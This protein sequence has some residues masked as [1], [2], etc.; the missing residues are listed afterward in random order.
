LWEEELGRRRREE[1][2][3]GSKLAL[4]GM[5]KCTY[6]LVGAIAPTRKILYFNIFNKF[7]FYLIKKLILLP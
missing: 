3:R 4:Q 6:K 5:D 7:Y 1:L 2:K